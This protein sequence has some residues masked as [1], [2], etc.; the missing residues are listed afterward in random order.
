ML[1]IC[2]KFTNPPNSILVQYFQLTSIDY[3]A[4]QS[5]Q[6]EV[7]RNAYIADCNTLEAHKLIDLYYAMILK[8]NRCV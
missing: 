5:S 8:H 6:W 2:Y 4:E 3:V 7:L 1:P